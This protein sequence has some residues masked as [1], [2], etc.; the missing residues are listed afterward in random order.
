MFDY[1]VQ[2]TPKGEDFQLI[3]VIDKE[4]IISALYNTY[5]AAS[6]AAAERIMEE[7]RKRGQRND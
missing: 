7:H 2:I 4:T 1:S 3:L 6:E 5:V